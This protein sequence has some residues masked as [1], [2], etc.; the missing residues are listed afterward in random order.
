V[1]PFVRSNV[2]LRLSLSRA[3]LFFASG[4]RSVVDII[5]MTLHPALASMR[6]ADFL[7]P[8]ITQSSGGSAS[9]DSVGEPTPERIGIKRLPI[10]RG[11]RF[12]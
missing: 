8:C 10:R 9:V 1:A 4:T 5:S 11:L 7:R 6:A 12:R 2:P 3:A